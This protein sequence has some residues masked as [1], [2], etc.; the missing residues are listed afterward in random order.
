M[1][2]VAAHG[3]FDV[4]HPGH[5][6]YL[7]AASSMGDELH[8]VVAASECLTPDS[9]PVVPDRQRRDTI[10][11][12]AVVD[13]ARLGDGDRRFAPL[14]EID[15]DVVVLDYDQHW[16]YDVETVATMLDEAGVDCEICFAP[17]YEPE[18]DV[19]IRAIDRS[20][21]HVCNGC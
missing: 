18:P 8:V 19:E 13:E 9:K 17:A 16:Q 15:P 3:T 2:R 4:V 5:L 21:E 6:H 20:F 1:R 11:A 10:A 7:E 14:S 12:L